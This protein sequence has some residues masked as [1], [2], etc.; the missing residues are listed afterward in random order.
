MTESVVL[1][2]PLRVAQDGIGLGGFLELFFRFRVAGVAIRM[3]L[4]RQLAVGA[5]DFLVGSAPGYAQNF[6]VITPGAQ[7]QI[8]YLPRRNSDHRRPQK[9]A[10]ECIAAAEFLNDSVFGDVMRRHGTDGLMK[11]GIER[12]ALRFDH[13]QAKAPKRVQELFIHKIKACLLYTSDAADER[14]SVD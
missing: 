14:S 1:R 2:S 7:S 8:S 3:E 6:V 4:H 5:L 11:I 12:L 13:L 10:V 9:L